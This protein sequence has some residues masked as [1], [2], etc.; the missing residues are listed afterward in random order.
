[1][2]CKKVWVL[3]THRSRF[4]VCYECQKAELK[5]NIKDP[6]MKRMFKIPEEFY[7]QS[8]FL[9][10][11]KINYLKFGELTPKQI[12]AFK[13]TVKDFKEKIKESKESS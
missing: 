7:K 10:S 4:I 6:K 12:E 8:M 2:M 1:M 9:R 5:G 13:K 3:A 11:I